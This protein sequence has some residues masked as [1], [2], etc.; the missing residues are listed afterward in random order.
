MSPFFI[1]YVKQKNGLM[2]GLSAV[3]SCSPT[4][5]QRKTVLNLFKFGLAKTGRFYRH[6]F[7]GARPL[8]VGSGFFF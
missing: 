2:D 7:T 5:F 1:F 3:L 8:P 6:Q 4:I